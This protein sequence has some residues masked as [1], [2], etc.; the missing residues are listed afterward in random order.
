IQIDNDMARTLEKKGELNQKRDSVDTI[1]RIGNAVQEKAFLKS[2][3]RKNAEKWFSNALALK[4]IQETK[5]GFEKSQQPEVIK[6]A[7]SWIQTITNNRYSL[8]KTGESK[9]SNE[10]FIL[11]DQLTSKK[12]EKEWSGGL[13][14]QVYLSIRM[15]LINE[16][17]KHGEILPIFLDDILIR[18]D[19]ERQLRTAELILNVSSNHQLFYFSCHPK[20]LSLFKSLEKN[21]SNPTASFYAIDKFTV[22]QI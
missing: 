15:G 8:M 22:S 20:I 18:F 21:S 3:L 4:I 6:F 5:S 13:A 9:K 12:T 11:F 7:S 1:T 16:L 17:S 19:S 10:S 14:D 2:E